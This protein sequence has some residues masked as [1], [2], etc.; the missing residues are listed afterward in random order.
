[1]VVKDRIEVTAS[2]DN[3]IAKIRLV[4]SVD[5]HALENIEFPA[6]KGTKVVEIDLSGVRTI[7]SIG[8][9]AW[10]NWIGTAPAGAA[11]TLHRCS[12]PVMLQV[13]SVAG[14]L[15]KSGRV[16]SFFLPYFC[17]TCTKSGQ[18]LIEVGKD[19]VLKD[20]KAEL[21]QNHHLAKLCDIKLNLSCSTEPE[22]SLQRYF[23]FLNVKEK[24]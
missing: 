23:Q 22:V 4:G 10:I 8:I 5:S 9:R 3:Q 7:N 15:P 11:I 16:G 18:Q 2:H 19:I 24:T 20:G 14:F 13:N 12:L 6:P 17:D 21:R 1:M